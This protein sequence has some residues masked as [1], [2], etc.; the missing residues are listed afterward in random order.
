MW[1]ICEA[2]EKTVEGSKIW[3]NGQDL[4]KIMEEQIQNYNSVMEEKNNV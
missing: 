4:N 2:V 1:N 3:R